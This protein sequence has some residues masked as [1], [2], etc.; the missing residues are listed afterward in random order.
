[1]AQEY[2][3]TIYMRKTLWAYLL[4]LAAKLPGVLGLLIFHSLYQAMKNLPA[5]RYRLG[6]GK[7]ETPVLISEI[8]EGIGFEIKITF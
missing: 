4:L 7:E 5:V 8:M 6:S 2:G 3:Y 1:M